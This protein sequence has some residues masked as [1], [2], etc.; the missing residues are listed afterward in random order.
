MKL[1]NKTTKDLTL[2]A[3]FKYNERD[4][5]T[6][7]NLYN[8]A[9]INSL[10]RNDYASNAPYSNKKQEFKVAANYKIDKRQSV[11]VAYNYDKVDRW[12][13]KYTHAADCIVAESNTEDR[14]G[15]KYRVKASDN[16]SLNAGY[17]YGDRKGSY[18]F[19]A[20]TPL[21]GLDSPTP[22]DVNSQNYPGYFAV[23]FAERKQD[24]LRLVP[25]GR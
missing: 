17:T 7:S 14:L 25:I 23:P 16:V 3:A 20:I 13:D 15:I 11:L 1:I 6:S 22:D 2:S 10:T 8:Y 12:C 18:D 9:A 19:D 24:L 21:S 5:N 4:N